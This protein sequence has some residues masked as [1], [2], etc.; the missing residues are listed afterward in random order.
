MN[1][2]K[3]LM[4]VFSGFLIFTLLDHPADA[5]IYKWKDEN[6]KIYFTDSLSK[7]PYK[8]RKNI[9]PPTRKSYKKSGQGLEYKIKSILYYVTIRSGRYTS[10]SPSTTIRTWKLRVINNNSFPME[11]NAKI[12]FMD[13]TGTIIHREGMY[14]LQITENSSKTFTEYTNLDKSLAKVIKK[15]SAEIYN[16]AEFQGNPI[17]IRVS[18]GKRRLIKFRNLGKNSLTFRAKVLFLDEDGF[19]LERHYLNKQYLKSG[20]EKLINIAFICVKYV[21]CPPGKKLDVVLRR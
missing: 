12:I 14:N 21:S 10:N 13:S 5:K 18:Y 1:F 9:K 20:G 17:P 2:P 3:I 7:V 4:T 8:Y 15:V 6:G 11:F 19:A 16:D